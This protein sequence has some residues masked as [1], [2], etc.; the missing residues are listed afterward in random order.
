MDRW[1][2]LGGEVLGLF[3]SGLPYIPIIAILDLVADGDD[4][5]GEPNVSRILDMRNF[6]DV[7][8]F[9][10]LKLF[11]HNFIFSIARHRMFMI[12]SKYVIK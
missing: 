9:S 7:C 4:L 10:K 1:C 8:E 11:E 5:K 12:M 3:L 2:E 6:V